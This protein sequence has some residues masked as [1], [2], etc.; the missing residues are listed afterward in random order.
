M[1]NK[2][3]GGFFEGLH[4]RI[5]Y[6]NNNILSACCNGG[7]YNVFNVRK[8]RKLSSYNEKWGL[9]WRNYIWNFPQNPFQIRRIH[10]EH[11]SKSKSVFNSEFLY[12]IITITLFFPP[13]Y[14][15]N[16]W[17]PADTLKILVWWFDSNVKFDFIKHWKFSSNSLMTNLMTSLIHLL[18]P[19]VENSRNW[20]SFF[21]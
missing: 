18:R 12:Y 20:E 4:I 13:F 19:L 1:Q 10:A 2:Y 9:I 11:V 6:T 16:E 14:P 7:N 5:F 8:W 17:T 3:V 21:L 15:L